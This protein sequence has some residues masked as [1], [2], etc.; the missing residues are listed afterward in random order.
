VSGTINLLGIY[1]YCDLPL[2][3]MCSIN[4]TYIVGL[5]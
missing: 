3:Y 1:Y 5:D 2:I 4:I